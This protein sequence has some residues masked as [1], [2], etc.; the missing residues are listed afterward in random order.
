MSEFVATNV[1]IRLLTRDDAGKMQRCLA[2]FWRAERG[3]VH[4]VTSESV[5]AEVVNVLSSPALYRLPRTEVARLVRPLLEVKGLG[6]DH[7]RSVLNALDLYAKSN[8]DFEDC[9]SV[10]HVRRAGLPGIYSYDRGLDR[11]ASVKRLEP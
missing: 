4:L 6:I 8:L 9:L 5:V 2:L 10:E 3:E 11:I 7:K 1:F